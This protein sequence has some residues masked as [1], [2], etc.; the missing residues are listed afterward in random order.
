M[1]ERIKRA[2]YFDYNIENHGINEHRLDYMRGRLVGIVQT[3]LKDEKFPVR[4]R[5]IRKDDKIVGKKVMFSVTDEEMNTIEKIFSVHEAF[6]KVIIK[7]E[8]NK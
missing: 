8:N 5:S 7:L 2:F 1:S 3:V 6:P 4:T